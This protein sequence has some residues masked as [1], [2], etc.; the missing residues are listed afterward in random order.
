MAVS[1]GRSS[2]AKCM[3]ASVN[4]QVDRER[5]LPLRCR[6]RR[7]KGERQV[8]IGTANR[9]SVAQGRRSAVSC[10]PI[11]RDRT[12]VRMSAA[13]RRLARRALARFAPRPAPQLPVEEP[14]HPRARLVGLFDVGREGDCTCSTPVL[15]E[16]PWSANGSRTTA[17][18]ISRSQACVAPEQALTRTTP[19]WLG[20]TKAARALQGA[21]LLS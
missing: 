9:E 6:C 2:S 7:R 18:T 1:P 21:L 4:W 10:Y 15:N 14:N 19:P 13:P 12:Q 17:C 8:R 5:Q 20:S 3:V 11:L 16:L